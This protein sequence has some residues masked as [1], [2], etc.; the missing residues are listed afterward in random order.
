MR[1]GFLVCAQARSAS[2]ARTASSAAWRAAARAPPARGPPRRARRRGAASAAAIAAASA[3]FSRLLRARSPRPSRAGSSAR[4]WRPSCSWPAPRSA[5]APRRSVI[6]ST[7]PS[8]GS[9][10]SL[11]IAT[12]RISAGSRSAS[13]AAAPHRL[14]FGVTGDRSEHVAVGD[15]RQRARGRRRARR[16]LRHHRQRLRVGQR[17]QAPRP[18]PGSRPRRCLRTPRARCRAA[19]R[20]PARAR[21]S[22]ASDFRHAGERGRIHQLG[23]RRAAH[24]RVGILPRDLG[25]Q[26]ALLER[27]LLDEGQADGGVGVLLTGLGAES[28]EQCHSTLQPD[29]C[30]T[31]CDQV[32]Q[33]GTPNPEEPYRTHEP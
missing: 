3:S 9:L 29:P 1:V 33:Y 19:W 10:N 5:R 28:I 15:A 18:P 20:S 2:S 8:V 26:I 12:L 23:D 30:G 31:A 4:A 13:N 24:P 16:G 21:A 32:R 14:V 22:S 17:R 25:E 7:A 27:N 6:R 11:L